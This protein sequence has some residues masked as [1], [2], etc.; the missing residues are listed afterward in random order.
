MCTNCKERSKAH[1]NNKEWLEWIG[2]TEV[3]IHVTND[4]EDFIK[5]E[6]ITPVS[7]ATAKKSQGGIISLENFL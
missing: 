1:K 3:S 6:P 4:I 2:N 5:Y 7:I